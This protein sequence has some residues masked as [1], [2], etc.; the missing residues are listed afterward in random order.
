M[1][2]PSGTIGNKTLDF[3]ALNAVPQSAVP[4]HTPLLVVYKMRK[5][6][7]AFLQSVEIIKWEEN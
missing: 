2:N 6:T 7:A 3:L 5:G 4:L 1:K